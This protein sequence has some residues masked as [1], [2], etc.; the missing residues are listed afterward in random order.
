MDWEQQPSS[1]WGTSDQHAT[2]CGYNFE[3]IQ[4]YVM[5]ELGPLGRNSYDDAGALAHV[6]VHMTGGYCPVNAWWDSFNQTLNFCDGDGDNSNELCV[7]DVAAH[8]Y[9]HAITDFTSGLT[10]Q[11]ESGALNESFSDIMGACVEFASQP[12][13]TAV[14]PSAT[15]GYSDWLIGEDAWLPNPGDAL[16][17]MR[18][19]QRLG[20]DNP[21]IIEVHF[22]ILVLKTMVVYIPIA[23]F[24]ILPYTC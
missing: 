22:G 19:P 16:R 3:I 1:D 20:Q 14:Y 2:S 7:L 6:N 12:P 18:D 10:Y 24:R 23:E 13:G 5:D 15:P 17:D 9:G 21:L 4:S 8:E 11:Y